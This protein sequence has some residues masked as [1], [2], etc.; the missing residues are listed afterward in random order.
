MKS[1]TPRITTLPNRTVITVSTIGAPTTVAQPAIERLFGTAY[2][3][4]FKV[5]KPAGRDWKIGQLAARWLTDPA[6][7]KTSWHA[8]W[9]LE[10]PA[11]TTV[12]E[13]I[14]KDP[15]APVAVAVW[16]GGTTAEILHVGAYADEQPTIEQLHAFIT[17]QGYE[18]CGPHEEVYLS[19]PTARA[20]KTL[21]RY[22]VRPTTP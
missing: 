4:K 14:Q 5:M 12:P 6:A 16:P 13:L 2:G 3:T 22:R 9:G 21:I 10:V 17:E 20:P 7:P 11:G 18:I 15:A 8:E 19:K 1:R